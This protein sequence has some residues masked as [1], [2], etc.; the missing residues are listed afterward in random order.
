[1]TTLVG[2]A[3]SSSKM[4]SWSRPT[5]E[6]TPWVVMARPVRRAARAAARWTRSSCAETH[7]LSVPISP[8]MPGRT[9]L[10]P[11]PSVASATSSSARSIHGPAIDQ[12]LGRV[13]GAAIPAAAH[14]D[15][16]VARPR[17][18]GQPGRVAP[19]AGEREVDQAAATGRAKR[20]Q[21]VQDHRLVAGELPVV[22]AVGDLPQRDLGVLVGQREPE[23]RRIDGTEDRLDVGHGPRCYAVALT[24]CSTCAAARRT[25]RTARVRRTDSSGR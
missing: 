9:P 13:V 10:S 23:L 15:V 22:P 25:S 14:D 20:G 12:R 16:Q 7:G 4:R 19:D 17:E 24:R 2:S 21:L 6:R 18:T 11:T 5:G 8:M 1:M 3:P